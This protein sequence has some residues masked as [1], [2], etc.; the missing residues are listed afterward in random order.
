MDLNDN[1][2]P[3][4]G[5]PTVQEFAQS[6]WISEENATIILHLISTRCG[7]TGDVALGAVWMAWVSIRNGMSAHRLIDIFLMI[8]PLPES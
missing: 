5:F 1:M 6:V 8:A 4:E 7:V 2:T 3:F